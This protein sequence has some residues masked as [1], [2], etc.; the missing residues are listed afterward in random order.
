[1]KGWDIVRKSLLQ[2]LEKAL[3]WREIERPKT[4]QRVSKLRY[5]DFIPYK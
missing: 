5:G 1:M 4:F 2:K 3:P